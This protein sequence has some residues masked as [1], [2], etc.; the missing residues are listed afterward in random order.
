MKL[1][2]R[3][4]NFKEG[5]IN[6][7]KSLIILLPFFFISGPFLTDFVFSLCALSLFFFLQDQEIKKLINSKFFGYFICFYLVLLLSSIMAIDKVLSLSNT[8]FYFRFGLFTI[9]FILLY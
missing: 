3:F 2:K 4:Y 6:I 7:N 9:F 1:T 5:I 8:I